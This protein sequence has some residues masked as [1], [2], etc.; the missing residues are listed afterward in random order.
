MFYANIG[1]GDGFQSL[2]IYRKAA[3]VSQTGRTQK[4][5]YKPHGERVWGMIMN[6]SQAEK[7]QWKQAGH[8]VTHKILQYGSRPSQAEPTDVIE[9][10][11]DKRSYYVQGVKDPIQIGVATTYYVEERLDIKELS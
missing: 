2:Q 6:A 9:A 1:V 8:P 5:T 10:T 7:E 4:G 11:R 3:E